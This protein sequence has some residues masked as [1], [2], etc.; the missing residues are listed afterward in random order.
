M[1]QWTDEDTLH[2]HVNHLEEEGVMWR[3]SLTI[4]VFL[5]L[6]IVHTNQLSCH[7]LKVSNICLMGA[8]SPIIPFS[9]T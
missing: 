3:E 1:L 5:I 9:C 6:N 8:G 4:D 7:I 2:V